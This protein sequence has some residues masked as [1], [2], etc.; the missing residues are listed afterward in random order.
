MIDRSRPD[1]LLFLTA[2]GLVAIGVVMIYSASAILALEKF[3][4]S[5]FFVKKQAMWGITALVVILVLTRVDYH[6][7]ERLSPFLLLGSFLLL[8]AVL[9]VPA[10]RGASRWIKAGPLTFQPSELFRYALIFFMAFS[11]S[12]RKEKIRELKFVLLPYFLL[13]IIALALIM[14]QPHLGAVL[15][16]ATVVFAM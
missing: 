4:S 5:T 14:K 2:L 9:F 7:L 3:G 12:R 16:I 1:Y 11:L 13:L 6:H 15:L 10:T 8:V